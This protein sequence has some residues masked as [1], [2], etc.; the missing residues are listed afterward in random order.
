MAQ[1]AAEGI[2][3][4]GMPAVQL[5]QGAGVLL[6][7]LLHQLFVGQSHTTVSPRAQGVRWTWNSS[8]HSFSVAMICLTYRQYVEAS[9]WRQCGRWGLDI[10]VME[11]RL[12]VAP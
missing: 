7:Q 10:C 12:S 4:P 11:R 9:S 5:T 2:E 8:H 6:L 3:A 1:F